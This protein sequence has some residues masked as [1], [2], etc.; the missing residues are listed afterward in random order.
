MSETMCDS[1]AACGCQN[2]NDHEVKKRKILGYGSLVVA[3]ALVGL[4]KFQHPP[5]WVHAMPAI[6]FFFGY[7][8]ILQAR[9]RTCVAL[10]FREADMSQGQLQPVPDRQT[11][12][13]LKVRSFKMIA[14]AAVLALLSAAI[15]WKL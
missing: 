14:L 10:A 5:E 6:P 9:T 11:G 8:N 4:A 3:F 12:W 2:L 15:C 13:M 1:P 7:L